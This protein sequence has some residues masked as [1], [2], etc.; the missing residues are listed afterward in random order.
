MSNESLYQ[1]SYFNRLSELKDY[2][3]EVFEAFIDFDQK[4]LA[5]GKL[6]TKF[7][8]L[9]AVAVAHVTGF[10]YC[11]ELHT[12]NVK[13]EEAS[14]EEMTEAIM[15]ATALKGGAAFAHSVNALNT[16]DGHEDE[17]L[18]KKSYFSRIKELSDLNN[19]AFEAFVN[20]DQQSMKE[21]KLSKKEKELIALA[22]AHVTGCAYCINIH[23]KGAKKTGSSPEEVAEAIFVA[24]SL[25]VG[26]AI[27]HS[28]NALNAYDG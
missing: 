13:K 6:T 12:Q 27:T 20:F 22:C 9:I 25:K 10:P 14:K 18:Y 15:V 5:P 23:G 3:P 4:A 24:T 11:I 16:Y 7:K 2:A 26:S 19:Q 17:E 1:K 28:A 8:E 21:G